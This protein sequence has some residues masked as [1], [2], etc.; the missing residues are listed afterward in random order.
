MAHDDLKTFLESNVPMGKK[1]SKVALGVADNKLAGSI[2]E[3][4]DVQCETGDVVLEV[5]RGIR[6]HFHKLIEGLYLFIILN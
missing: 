2:Q 1:K 6:V 5:V 3:G 4:V